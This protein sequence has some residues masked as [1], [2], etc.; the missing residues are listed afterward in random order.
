MNTYLKHIDLKSHII[1]CLIWF[2]YVLQLMTLYPH[3]L[4]TVIYIGISIYHI[5]T[6]LNLERLK[7]KK[8]VIYLLYWI[9]LILVYLTPIIDL[10]IIFLLPLLALS[11]YLGIHLY[12]HPRHF[13]TNLSMHKVQYKQFIAL[14]WLFTLIFFFKTDLMW[15]LILLI[16]IFV[17]DNIELMK[18]M[19]VFE[20]RMPLT[21]ITIIM[22]GLAY[23]S[24]TVDI[25]GGKAYHIL[26]NI[27]FLIVFLLSITHLVWSKMSYK[28]HVLETK[29]RRIKV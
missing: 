4:I 15:V 24:T 5:M 23:L 26:F 1:L 12:K 16:P 17:K 9:S 29:E 14:I 21:F 8:I 28:K 7:G 19:S 22:F 13:P 11:I 25:D 2:S 18:E 20:K 3:V 6:T 27:D 10:F